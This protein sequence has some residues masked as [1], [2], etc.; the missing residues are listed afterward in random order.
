MPLYDDGCT[1][2]LAD[3]VTR[4]SVRDTTRYGIE[5]AADRYRR[6]DLDESHAHAALVIGPPHGGVKEQSPGGDAQEMA[7]RGFVAIGFDPS[8]NGQ[9]SGQ[10]RRT[11]LY[12]RTDLI[13][14][15]RLGTF[16]ATALTDEG[17][18]A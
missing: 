14:F 18:A 11:D 2:A 7:R 16:F 13:P 4:T 12:D 8:Y 3:E 5:I 1:F 9:S 6:R 15:D 17:R 10:P